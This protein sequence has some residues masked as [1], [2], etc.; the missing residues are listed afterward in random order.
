MTDLYRLKTTFNGGEGGPGVATMYFLDV[1]TAVESV[2]NF[3]NSQAGGMP[4]GTTIQVESEGDV[5]DD[6]SGDVTGSW[7]QTAAAAIVTTSPVTYAAAAGAVI[8]WRTGVVLDGRRLRGRT[9]VVPL[10]SIAFGTDGVL[11]DAEVASL[12]ASANSL[13]STQS[14]SFVVWHR[15]F[16]GKAATSTRPARPAHDGGHALVSSAQVPKRG[17]VLRSR[18]D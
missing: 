3:W 6:A 8:S 10:P 9:F 4:A 15:K 12:Q 13:I 7:T 16:L 18:R 11:T 14:E 17:A 1:A 5:L 2:Y